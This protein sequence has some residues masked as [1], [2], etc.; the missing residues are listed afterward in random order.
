M[1]SLVSLISG[2]FTRSLI[3]GAFLPVVVFLALGLLTVQPL[4]ARRCASR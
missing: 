2:Q 3:F 4:L 1:N